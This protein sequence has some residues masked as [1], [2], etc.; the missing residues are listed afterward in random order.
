MGNCLA[1]PDSLLNNFPGIFPAAKG[2]YNSQQGRGTN[3]KPRQRYGSHISSGLDFNGRTIFSSD[4]DSSAPWPCPVIYSQ[5]GHD[6]A[7]EKTEIPDIDNQQSCTLAHLLAKSFIENG[8]SPKELNPILLSS[9]KKSSS[10]STSMGLVHDAWKI[11][12]ILR[13]KALVANL[14]D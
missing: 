14:L 6:S 11:L 13:Q 5:M 8:N 9:L 3:F 10:K 1:K 12:C 2:L 7:V 4:K